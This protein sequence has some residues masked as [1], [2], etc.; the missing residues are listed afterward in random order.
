MNFEPSEAQTMVAE[1][2]AR[3]L[4]EHSSVAR[5]RAAAETGFDGA[6][7]RGV[8][9]M[10]AFSMRVPEEAGGLGLG[11]LDV[12][13]VAAEIGRT[14]ASG[15]IIEGVAAARLLALLGGEPAR[16][17]LGRLMDGEAVV[18]LALGD[19]G[20]E[21]A[22]WVPGGAAA[23]AVLA[24]DGRCVF[25]VEPQDDERRTQPNLASA[26]IAEIR[27]DRND[28][29]VLAEGPEAVRAFAA[30]VEEWKLFMAAALAGLSREAI[31]LAAAYATERQA[32]GQPIGGYQGV[33]HPLADLGADVQ[34]GKFLVW[35]TIRDIADGARE[36][37]AEISAAL[38]WNAK[39]AG[40]AGAQALHTF[41]GY[42]LTTEYDIHLYT[43]R[44]KA[45]P[46]VLGDPAR[47]LEEAARRRYAGEACVLPEAGEAPIDF[48]LGEE[49]KALAA[50]VDAFVK[51]TIT[52]QLRAKA[53]Y[54]FDGYD[55]EVHRKAAQ[56]RLLYPHW[57]EEWGGRG[58]GPAAFAAVMG[59]WED[60]DWTTHPMATD[61]MV[62][63]IMQRFGSDQ[64]KREALSRVAAG[65]AITALGFSEPGSGSDVFAAKTRATRDGDGW[66]IDGQKMFTSGAN[67]A[68][69]VL[70][71][72]RTN[73]DVAKHRG[74]TMFIVPLKA[75]GVTVQPV[76]TF[77]DERTNITYYDG[78]RIPDSYRLGEV[79]GG[80]KVMAASLELEH[81][82]NW[83]RSQT[84]LLEAAEEACRDIRRDGRP[85]I[86]DPQ[87]AVR[88]ARV[89]A[90]NA[91]TQVLVS[92]AV[93]AVSEGRPNQ[94]QG[95]MSKL[96]SS[97]KFRTDSADLLDLTAPLSLLKRDGP[98]AFIN[99]CYRHSQA[100]TVYAGTSEVHR[101][102]VAER[103]LG[104][105][106]TRA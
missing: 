61:A 39:T 28:R 67:L 66:R 95:S 35:K 25:L 79:D 47:L 38:W 30:A 83:L 97:E 15:P 59:A 90:H 10:G 18:S 41:G 55:P 84:R 88:L 6:L 106:R 21:P 101:S 102:V 42:G 80:I 63:A 52:P 104:L 48:E 58:L 53:H 68:D 9:E 23:D 72:T 17:L 71:L 29:H 19:A 34:A 5:V 12:A 1:T 85:L 7:W 77:Q 33:S 81:G 96:F 56:A 60:N 89:A 26:A 93:W 24:C 92:Y 73:P 27:L 3:F 91:L 8:A 31:R 37:G 40:L 100:T 70:L 46:L 4:D 69:Y 16:T 57:P 32:F 64:L 43:V 75:A 14:L 50:E 103:A 51:A 22:Q 49:A 76:F 99:Q 62:G 74:L 78:V 45:W 65:E 20:R 105:P 11:L 94:G 13:L 2:F 82:T 87:V 54:S 86:E 98:T 36:A 44:A